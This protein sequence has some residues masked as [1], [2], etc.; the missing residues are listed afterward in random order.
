MTVIVPII[1][2]CVE[3]EQMKIILIFI[4]KPKKTMY[5]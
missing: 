3:M 5:E 4:S 1:F 2:F